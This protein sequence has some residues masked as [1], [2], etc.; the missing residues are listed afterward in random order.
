MHLQVCEGEEKKENTHV[1]THLTA[2][3]HGVARR[4]AWAHNVRVNSPLKSG[5]KPYRP[6][7]SFYHLFLLRVH[8]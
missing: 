1:L 3:G 4:W 2:P 6:T 8:I 7:T 5:P